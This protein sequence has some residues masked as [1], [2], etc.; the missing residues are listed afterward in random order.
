MCAFYLGVEISYIYNLISFSWILL[1]PTK[2]FQNIQN[3]QYNVHHEIYCWGRN[4]LHLAS[5]RTVHLE[6]QKLKPAS[7]NVLRQLEWIFLL[8]CLHFIT[9]LASPGKK[10]QLQRGFFLQRLV[11]MPASS[12]LQ[13]LSFRFVG[14]QF[15]K[16]ITGLCN[17]SKVPLEVF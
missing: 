7:L 15:F 13:L 3:G 10:L 1:S 8:L 11:N 5:C 2:I 17:H 14:S 16:Q 4:F 9:P 6:L 12:H